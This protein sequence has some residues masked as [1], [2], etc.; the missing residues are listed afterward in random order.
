MPDAGVTPLAHT[1]SGSAFRCRAPVAGR[2]FTLLEVL[3]AVAILGVSVALILSILAG[4]RARIL[5][6]ERNWARQHLLA[7]A[8]EWYLLAGVTNEPPSGLLPPGFAARAEL[9]R[10]TDLPVEAQDPLDGW[11]L[12]RFMIQLTGRAGEELGEL[13]IDKLVREDAL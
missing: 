12:G 2:R 11:V 10:I 8:A 5:R 4:A 13:P 9:V 1:P 3:I 6:A 7:Q